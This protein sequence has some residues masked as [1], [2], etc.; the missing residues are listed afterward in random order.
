ME[1]IGCSVLTF[2]PAVS[3]YSIKDSL[4]NLSKDNFKSCSEITE[5]HLGSQDPKFDTKDI[6]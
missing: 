3:D 5:T 4:A 2:P 1:L 6:Y